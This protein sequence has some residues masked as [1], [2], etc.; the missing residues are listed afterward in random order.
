[1]RPLISPEFE[2]AHEERRSYSTYVHKARTGTLRHS[3]KRAA[4]HRALR[5]IDRDDV[6]HLTHRCLLR[7]NQR[8]PRETGPARLESSLVEGERG[9]RGSPSCVLD[10]HGSEGGVEPRLAEC[11]DAATEAKDL[12]DGKAHEMPR[13]QRFVSG[14]SKSHPQQGHVSPLPANRSRAGGRRYP[15]LY[16]V[17]RRR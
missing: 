5:I 16:A 13:E 12:F 11:L 2:V 15:W 17:I 8:G 1:L 6:S 10:R 3:I 4:E 14:R 7:V 9:A